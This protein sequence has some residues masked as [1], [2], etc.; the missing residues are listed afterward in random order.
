MFN[1]LSDRLQSIFGGL[2]SKG[3]LNEE[4]INLAMR[5]IRMAL[6]EADVNFR[7]ARDFIARTKARCLTAEVLDSL[8]PA[9]NVVKVVMEELT[10]VLGSEQAKLDLGVKTPAVI[11]LVGLQGSGKTTAA[12]KLAYHLKAKKHQPLLVACD[13]YRPAAADQL[14]TL[15][16]VFIL[17]THLHALPYLLLHTAQTTINP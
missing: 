17:F 7:V 14:A 5:E 3:R 12:A 15:G 16:A 9:Q 10:A 6:L 11:M 8:T 4:D 13:V 2:R 1:N